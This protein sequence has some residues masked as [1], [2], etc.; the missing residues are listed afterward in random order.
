MRY[1]EIVAVAEYLKGF[2][3]I[4]SAKRVED[5]TLMLELDRK[6]LFF[7]MSKG[8]SKIYIREDFVYAKEY[9]APFDVALKKRL[10]NVKIKKVSVDPRDRILNI[11][12]EGGTSY[13]RD[14]LVLRFEFLGRYSNVILLDQKG[15]VIEALRHYDDSCGGREIKPGKKLQPP[16][17]MKRAPTAHESIEDVEEYLKRVYKEEIDKKLSSLK[18]LRIM[19]IEKKIDKLSQ[20][21]T[22]LPAEEELS[23]EADILEE[24]ANLILA[25]LNLIK[26]YQKSIEIIDFNGERRKLELPLEAKSVPDMA[27]ILFSKAK[28]L[29][30]K[31]KNIHI[32]RENIRSKVAFLKRIVSRIEKAKKPEDIEIFF[33]KRSSRERSHKNRNY[34]RFKIGEYDIFVGKNEKGNQELLKRASAGDIWMH[35]KDIPSAHLIIKSPKKTP[36]QEVLQK[37][38]DIC[39]D[40]SVDRSGDYLVDYARRRD[41]KI[42]NGAKVEYVN[43]KTL[44]ARKV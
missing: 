16:A 23:K 19:Q 21:L 3:R 38:A 37:A 42:K 44:K 36:P 41:V 6:R 33:P 11:E 26:P 7:D 34:E 9:G 29:R 28:K 5:N 27:N 32:E 35:I 13:K 17:P 43:Y 15:V 4:R 12:V 30:Q 2:D 25:N 24:E 14:L 31:A 8:N 18:S 20:I 39:V 10:S 40:L 1:F 22:S